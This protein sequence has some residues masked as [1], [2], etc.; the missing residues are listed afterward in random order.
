MKIENWNRQSDFILRTGISVLTR[1]YF[2]LKLGSQ[3]CLNHGRGKCWKVRMIKCRSQFEIYRVHLFTFYLFD[4]FV[5]Y[6]NSIPITVHS[7]THCV[8][9]PFEIVWCIRQLEMCNT[10]NRNKKFSRLFA[11]IMYKL[12]ESKIITGAISIQVGFVTELRGKS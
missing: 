5:S 2:S 1:R 8:Y 3:Q 4:D 9:F 10:H 6:V 11:Q 12:Y 7:C